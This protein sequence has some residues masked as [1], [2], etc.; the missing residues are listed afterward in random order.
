MWIIHKDSNMYVNRPVQSTIKS[1]LT[2]WQKLIQRNYLARLS[3]VV[4]QGSVKHTFH[5]YTVCKLIFIYKYGLQK[6]SV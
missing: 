6:S 5:A 2:F 4:Y 3:H 1:V